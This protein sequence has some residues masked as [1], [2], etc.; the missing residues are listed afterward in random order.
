MKFIEELDAA[1][2]TGFTGSVF[3]VDDNFIGNKRAVKALLQ[4]IIRWQEEHGRPF[5]FCTEASIDLA[6]DD[7]LLNLMAEAGFSMVFVGLESPDPESLAAAGKLQNLRLDVVASV[8]K[9]QARGIEVT[10]GFIIGFDSDTEEIFDLQIEFIRELAIPTAMVGLLM[11]L[12]QTRLYERLK[13]EG[14][15]LHESAGN[16][17]HDGALNFVTR[18]PRELLVNGYERVLTTIYSPRVYFD[19]CLSVL[20]RYPRHE[21]VKQLVTRI[22]GREIFGLIASLVRQILSPYGF[23]YLRY[24]ALAFRRRPDLAVKIVTMAIQG[25][26]Y[27]VITRRLVERRRSAARRSTGAESA[28]GRLNEL[29]APALRIEGA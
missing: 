21:R 15:I 7:E 6:A 3:V 4:T 29:P 13:R 28:R 8:K 22:T 25:H 26:H 27:F 1:Y 18:L 19:R 10:G 23:F 5:S 11:A 20:E 12:P 14:R 2:A 16:N 9:I 17:T 24:L